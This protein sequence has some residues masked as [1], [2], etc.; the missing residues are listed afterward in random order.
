M[1]DYIV[2]I[3]A[4]II[5]QN[6]INSTPQLTTTPTE[7]FSDTVSV[8]VNGKKNSRVFVNGVDVAIIEED[9]N[10]IIDLNTSGADGNKDFEITL[11]D[12]A[13]HIS[14][15]LSFS[16]EKT[17]ITRKDAIKL[18]RQAAFVS[19]E[20]HIDYIMQ[21]GEEAW[22]DKQ[23]NTIGD[24]DETDDKYGY[25]E[26]MTRFLHENNPTKYP[27][28]LFT[29]P[30]S[31]YP[32]DK[33]SLRLSIFNRSIWW[34][35]AFHNEDQLRQRVAYA[36]SQLLVVGKDGSNHLGFRGE[37]AAHYYDILVTCFWKL[38]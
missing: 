34:Q 27:N 22:I 17:A 29:D 32:E 20:S 25:L 2:P 21:N 28:S 7:T 6:F 30:F 8:E 15:T 37:A 26:S 9:G 35:K 18:L 36:L 31:A 16:L 4:S 1:L 5:I 11:H 19:D 33:D 3:L 24:L 38:W 12:N 10:V 13:N 14:K 23:L